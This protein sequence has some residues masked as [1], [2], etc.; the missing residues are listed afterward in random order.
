[1]TPEKERAHVVEYLHG[2]ASRYFATDQARAKLLHEVA[3]CIENE[4]HLADVVFDPSVTLLVHADG[5]LSEEY[6]ARGTYLKR[7]EQWFKFVGVA[8]D[9][10]TTY[11]GQQLE[12]FDGPPNGG[13]GVY[14]ETPGLS[15]PSPGTS[16]EKK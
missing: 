9:V 3:E 7:G 6:E 2:V 15:T 16:E 11:D 4:I 14:L 8:R 5:T 10:N 1:M 12:G 13:R